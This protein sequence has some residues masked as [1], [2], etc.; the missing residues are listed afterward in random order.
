MFKHRANH[1]QKNLRSAR[2]TRDAVKRLQTFRL[3]V[4]SEQH[5][6]T[7]SKENTPDVN[8]TKT[9]LER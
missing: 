4:R 6:S 7:S 1:H 3:S 5:E 9:T 2:H 8:G